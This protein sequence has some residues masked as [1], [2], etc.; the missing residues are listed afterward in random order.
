MQ[1]LKSSKISD[2]LRV[3]RKRRNNEII[4]GERQN[5]GEWQKAN[6]KKM[7]ERIVKGSKKQSGLK[8]GEKLDR[9]ENSMQ[10]R[11][12]K[13]VAVEGPNILLELTT[14]THELE[15]A[16]FIN[17]LFPHLGL[18]PTRFYVIDNCMPIAC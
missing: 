9:E 8:D 14:W 2:G 3:K 16:Y 5:R 11:G 18:L 12:R 1:E 10:L 4:G 15:T 7:E 13:K 17:I 6:C